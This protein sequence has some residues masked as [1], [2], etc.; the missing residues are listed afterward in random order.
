MKEFRACFVGLD[1]PRKGNAV[2]HD[3]HELLLIA[4]LT[5]LCGGESCV[6]MEELAGAKEDFLRSFLTLPG[7]VPSHDTFSRLFR[8][9]FLGLGPQWHRPN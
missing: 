4:L 6:D 9:R 5:F 8:A 3:L 7:G 1:D 2:Q